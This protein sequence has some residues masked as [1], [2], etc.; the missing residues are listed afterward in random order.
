MKH[1]LDKADAHSRNNGADKH[2]GD[3]LV[4]T[5]STSIAKYPHSRVA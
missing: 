3:F 2:H 5:S 4:L 1:V